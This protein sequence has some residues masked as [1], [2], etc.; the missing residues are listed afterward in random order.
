MQ[1]P[2]HR[3]SGPHNVMVSVP[4]GPAEAALSSKP[5][6][7]VLLSWLHELMAEYSFAIELEWIKSA[8]NPIADA[9]SR[10]EWERFVR[11]AAD[12]GFPAHSLSRL[13]MP[14]RSCLVSTMISAQLS[15][16]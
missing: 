10:G 1:S 2:L 15:T 13:Q 11:S 3:S 8:D 16:Q 14:A 12:S 6:I 5:A 7:A 4:D 9:L